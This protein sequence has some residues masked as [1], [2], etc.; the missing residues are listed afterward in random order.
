ML[1]ASIPNGSITH[2]FLRLF[3]YTYIYIIM[4]SSFISAFRDSC[5]N[6]RPPIFI[7]NTFGLLI[8]DLIIPFE[9]IRLLFFPCSCLLRIYSIFQ[10][11]QIGRLY[12][13]L[14]LAPSKS[15]MAPHFKYIHIF[16]WPHIFSCTFGPLGSRWESLV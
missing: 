2:S 7:Q 13:N 4:S 16:P 8:N 10:K 6:S 1:I 15:H 5:E 9:V 12:H 14:Y 11:Y 3:T